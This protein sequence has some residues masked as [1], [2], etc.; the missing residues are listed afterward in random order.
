[1]RI[2]FAVVAATVDD[3]SEAVRCLYLKIGSV[4]AE[5]LHSQ[6]NVESRLGRRYRLE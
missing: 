3:A 2:H 5:S 6:V 4:A 1:M